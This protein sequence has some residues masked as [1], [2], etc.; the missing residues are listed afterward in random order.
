MKIVQ[1]FVSHDKEFSVF[2]NPLKRFRQERSM[3]I[4]MFDDH[5]RCFCRHECNITRKFLGEFR[6]GMMGHVLEGGGDG[7]GKEDRAKTH[8]GSV[9]HA[10]C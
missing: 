3:I 7:F 8:L 2:G 1:D 5:F 6:S 9:L 10:T 4:F